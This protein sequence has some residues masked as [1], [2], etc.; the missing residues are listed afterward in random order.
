LSRPK[1]TPDPPPEGAD[2]RFIEWANRQFQRIEDWWPKD[3][4]DR[5]RALEL[6]TPYKSGTWPII[7]SSSFRVTAEAIRQYELNCGAA[8][9]FDSGLTEGGAPATVQ[10]LDGESVILVDAPSSSGDASAFFK[11][12]YATDTSSLLYE[13]PSAGLKCTAF[14]GAAPGALYPKEKVY[15]IQKYRT[16]DNKCRIR[17]YALDDFPET[18][19]PVSNASATAEVEFD[20][21]TLGIYGAMVQV[22]QYAEGTNYIF[23]RSADSAYKV[24]SKTTGALLGGSAKTAPSGYEIEPNFHGCYFPTVDKFASV[25]A[26]SSTGEYG[27]SFMAQSGGNFSA[28]VDLGITGDQIEWL[29]VFQKSR[30]GLSEDYAYLLWLD[31]STFK[32]TKIKDDGSVVWTKDD[33]ETYINSGTLTSSAE[34]NFSYN[35]TTGKGYWSNGAKIVEYDPADDTFATC[36]ATGHTGSSYGSVVIPSQ[37]ANYGVAGSSGTLKIWKKVIF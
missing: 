28:P 24:F 14:A 31:G 13:A 34:G 21:N 20:T 4:G 1:F 12:D 25:F 33:T 30:T 23:V 15:V 7:D 36:N 8:T 3:Y 17:R 27:I 29:E 22:D 19:S 18:A 9:A 26:D 5:L 2:P 6:L 32:L 35:E 16:S 37:D 10:H 11:F